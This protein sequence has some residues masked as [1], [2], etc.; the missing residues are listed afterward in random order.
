MA[1][2]EVKSSFPARRGHRGHQGA[3]TI[4][5]LGFGELKTKR[6]E[7]KN[8]IYTNDRPQT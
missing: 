7:K 4:F 3:L 2:Q 5:S 8:V 6:F 1:V